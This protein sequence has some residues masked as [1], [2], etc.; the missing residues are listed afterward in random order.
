MAGSINVRSSGIIDNLD[1]YIFHIMGCGAIGSSVAL[2]LC[3]MGARYFI[4]YDM[5]KVEELN[6]G[7]S[8]YNLEDVG[9]HKT[10]AL[11]KHLKLNNPMVDVTTVKGKFKDLYYQQSNDIVIL[12]FDNMKARMQVV[13]FIEENKC[14][15]MLIDGRMGAEE[16]QQYTFPEFKKR[17]YLRYWYSDD[18]ASEDP[19]NA[20]ATSYCSNMAGSFIA[21]TVRKVVTGQMY[22]EQ[23]QFLFPNM[24]L[25]KKQISRNF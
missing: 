20:K 17:N 16:Y 15:V 6:V 24:F 19:C 9:K 1:E 12:G 5:D 25:E 11:C 7:V 10:D 8:I 3:K 23:I 4:L 13:D 22:E 14:K 18:E 2:Q 21:N